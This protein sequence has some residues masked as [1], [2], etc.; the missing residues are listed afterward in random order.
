M[1]FES[2]RDGWTATENSSLDRVGWEDEPAAVTYGEYALEVSVEGEFEPAIENDDRIRTVD[3]TTYHC[4]LADVLPTNVEDSESPVTFQFRYHHAD[5][6]EESSEHTV[7]QRYGGRLCWD[8]SD[9]SETALENPDRLELTW[10]PTDHSS[11]FDYAG[12]VIVDNIY[13]T[14]HRNS[15]TTAA[16]TRKHR[17]LEREHGPRI[18]QEIESEDDTLQEGMYEYSDGTEVAYELEIYENGEIEERVDDAAFRW[19]GGSA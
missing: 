10:S 19:E 14:D 16:C 6:V 3:L 9:L 1:A 17:D 11:E 12:R 7:D 5:G 15:V 13:L 18:G 2:G 4:L 8:M